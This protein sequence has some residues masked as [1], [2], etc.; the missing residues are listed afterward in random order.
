[1]K[2]YLYMK[3]RF[4]A[5]VPFLKLDS[6]NNKEFKLFNGAR[7]SKRRYFLRCEHS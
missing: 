6:I 2:E 7:I 5:P 3:Y 1:M 4:I